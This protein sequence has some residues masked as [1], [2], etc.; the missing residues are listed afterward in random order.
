[1]AAAITRK[2]ITIHDGN[3][4]IEGE[5]LGDEVRVSEG[6]REGEDDEDVLGEGVGDLFGL[7]EGYGN[8]IAIL[9]LL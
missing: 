3:S 6:L 2:T 5:G 1:V 9:E 4:G 8:P 7:G